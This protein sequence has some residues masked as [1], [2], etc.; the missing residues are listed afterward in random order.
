M[1]WSYTTVEQLQNVLTMQEASAIDPPLQRERLLSI[2]EGASQ[3][4]DREAER[5][6][7][8]FEGTYAYTPEFH[9]FHLLDDLLSVTTMLLDY[10]QDGTREVTLS[11]AND[12]LLEPLNA[13][14]KERPYTRMRIR[15]DSQ[16]YLP[17]YEGALAISGKWGYWERLRDTGVTLSANIGASDEALAVSDYGRIQTGWTLRI[18]SEQCYVRDRHVD[19][20]G[21]MTVLRGQN[22]TT[23][24]AHDAGATI[25]RYVYP[26]AIS[27]AA[28]MM[29][30]RI[31]RR[32]ETPLGIVNNPGDI[33]WRAVYIP[34]DD[35]DV[36]R[37]LRA[38][39]KRNI[40]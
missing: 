20:A 9:D 13:L 26:E 35:V 11:A 17:R 16:Y 10:N 37:L 30:A 14:A 4:I 7:R 31:Y 8:I 19:G 5:T 21:T 15:R 12:Y 29:A 33:G 27:Q 6:F 40:L 18:G 36:V 23:A 3:D 32:S 39:R 25:A 28:L 2:I 1:A 22:G 34:K 24:V 38:F